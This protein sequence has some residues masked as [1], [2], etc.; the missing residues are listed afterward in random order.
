MIL[1]IELVF[2]VSF[3]LL[4]WTHLAYP[5]A[6]AVLAQL[7]PRPVAAADVLPTVSLIIPAYNEERVLEAKLSNALALDYPPDRLEVVVTSDASTDATHRIAESFADRGVR[8]IVCERG[9]KVAAQDRAVRET[10]GEVVAFGDANV[11]WE[12]DALRR[13]VRAFADP[14]VG[15]VCGGVRLVNPAGGTN[16]E[17]VYWRYEMWLR[18]RE[19]RIGSV[20]GGNGAIYAVRRSDYVEVDPRFGHDLSFPYLMVQHGRRAVYEPRA[21]ATENMTT[22]IGDEF[23]RKVRMFEHCWLIVFKGRMWS[24]RR[25]GL[26]YWTVLFSHRL[27]RYGSGPLHVVWLAA[28]LALASRGGVYLWLLVAQLAGLALAGLSM[29][30]GG[31]VRGISVLHYYTLVTLATVIALAGYLRRGVPA[32]WDKAV[33]TR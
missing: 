9:G 33:G 19:S 13:L 8:L 21:R 2:W 12:P 27:L 7:R 18:E 4:V 6:V 22:D 32:T 28:S 1:L 25:D 3:A 23:R 14:D 10:S 16:Q 11:T 24:V 17:G 15:M 26:G 5:P 31:R 29:A 20:T 30:L